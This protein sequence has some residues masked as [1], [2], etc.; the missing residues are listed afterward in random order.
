[1]VKLFKD[2]NRIEIAL[3]P[4]NIKLT[5]TECIILDKLINNMPKITTFEELVRVVWGDKIDSAYLVAIRA[6]MARLRKKGVKI[7]AIPKKGYIL[8]E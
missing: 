1:M 3:K 2:E 5:H 4:L 6:H 8:D 7:K